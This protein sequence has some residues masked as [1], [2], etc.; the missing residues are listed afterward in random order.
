MP[1][2]RSGGGVKKETA[3]RKETEGESSQSPFSTSNSPSVDQKADNPKE[4]PRLTAQEKKNNHILSE[5]KRR[6]A[7][8]EG[9][10]RLSE[11][12]PGLSGCFRSEGTMLDKTTAFVA[13]SIDERRRLVQAIEA[14]G[15]VVPE[16]L[17]TA[18]DIE[19]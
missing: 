19:T 6:A 13:E 8:R 2:K 12:V 9:F 16:R 10:E 5:Q 14:L 3:G 18:V 17:K 1:P 15:G 11:L 7:I 4:R